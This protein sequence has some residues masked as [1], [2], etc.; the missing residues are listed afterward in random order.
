[1]FGCCSGQNKPVFAFLLSP[2]LAELL[3]A[4]EGSNEP[5]GST[6]LQQQQV[7]LGPVKLE[8][9]TRMALELHLFR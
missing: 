3:K 1:M 4:P 2:V 5:M 9:A 6:L 8:Q 7:K